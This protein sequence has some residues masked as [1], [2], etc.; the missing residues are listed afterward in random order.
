MALLGSKTKLVWIIALPLAALVAPAEA[1][2][3]EPNPFCK[4]C[5]SGEW[6]FWNG[7]G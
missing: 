6:C 3:Q 4:Q 1:G 5:A 2:A 7:Y